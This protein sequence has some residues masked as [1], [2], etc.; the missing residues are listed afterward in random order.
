MWTWPPKGGI[1][2]LIARRAI[3]Q[4]SAWKAVKLKNLPAV[5]PV[6]LKNP[7]TEGVSKTLWTRATE[8]P[9]SLLLFPSGN[10]RIGWNKKCWK[11]NRKFLRKKISIAG[12]KNSI[13]ENI[14]TVLF[15]S[16]WYKWGTNPCIVSLNVVKFTFATVPFYFIYK[17]CI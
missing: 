7:H 17:V 16:F 6:H 11:C 2:I 4:P 3:P 12:I 9:Y 8:W 14:L 10:A 13:K 5:R 1:I 15:K